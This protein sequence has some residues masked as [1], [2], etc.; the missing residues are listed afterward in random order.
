MATKIINE[1]DSYDPRYYLKIGIIFSFFLITIYFLFLNTNHKNSV[2]FVA[3]F[4]YI[5]GIN[6]N[7]E[8]QIAG[9]KVGEISKIT[10]STDKVIV[11]GYIDRKYNIPNDSILKI[12]S[13]GIF[14]K[15]TIFI[16]PGF[17]NFLNKSNEQYVFTQ[18]QDSY[19]VDMFLRYLNNLNE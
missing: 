19:S 16:E 6:D 11:N 3:S 1:I 18:T 8:V 13:D 2:P 4:N 10:L 12:K 17:G 5:E 7:T 14:G 9:I 15:K